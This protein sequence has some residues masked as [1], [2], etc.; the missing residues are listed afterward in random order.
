[1]GRLAERRVRAAP[2]TIA[3]VGRATA[4]ADGFARAGVRA[5]P[6]WVGADLS[7]LS[8][9]ALGTGKRGATGFHQRA[10]SARTT[11]VSFVAD[12]AGRDFDDDEIA[13]LEAVRGPLAALYRQVRAADAARAAVARFRSWLGAEGWC[14]IE[15]DADLRI[16]RANRCGLAM[17]GVA[18]P[19]TGLRPG[20]TLPSPIGAWLRH[21]NHDAPAGA[22][23]TLDNGAR[24]FA[25]RALPSLDADGW[26]LYVAERTTAGA[27]ASETADQ[28]DGAPMLSPREREVLRWVAA[29]KT[30]AQAAAILGISVRTVQKHLEH[31]YV[32]L[33]VE[34]RTA[35][36]MRSR[37]VP[38][39]GPR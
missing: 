23:L 18:V 4:N 3:A 34:G 16:R 25:L 1:M 30:D 21:A 10:L 15:V 32:K 14:E 36:V 22:A 13:A 33:G 12:R 19:A 20:A 37:A 31:V 29:G 24:R 28:A 5:L 8:V 35:A 11:L 9:C 2:K 39:N 17:L 27:A 6:G 7:T 26:L 38:G